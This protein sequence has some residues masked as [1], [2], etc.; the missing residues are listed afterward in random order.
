MLNLTMQGVE[1]FI[2]R[3]QNKNQESFWD[4]Y[5]LIIWKNNPNA[6]TD[7]NGMFRNSWGISEKVIVNDQGVWELPKKYVKYFK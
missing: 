6:Y 7:K 4:N 5:D 3:F 1:V 2:K